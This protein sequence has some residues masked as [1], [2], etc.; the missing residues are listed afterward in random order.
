[1]SSTGWRTQDDFREAIVCGSCRA[2]SG[3]RDW[4][5]ARERPCITRRSGRRR[6]R[7]SGGTFGRSQVGRRVLATP[8]GNLV[9]E[10]ASMMVYQA[11]VDE[12]E[13]VD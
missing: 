6:H 9:E 1:M 2:R 12:R 10:V 13:R 7:T 5:L 11:E 4:N 8:R 3:E